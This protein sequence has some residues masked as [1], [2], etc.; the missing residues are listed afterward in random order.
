MDQAH[1]SRLANALSYGIPVVTLP[2]GARGY[3]DDVI[4]CELD[5]VPE[6][7]EAIQA[8]WATHSRQ[9][10]SDAQQFYNWATIRQQFA[11]TIH[12]LQ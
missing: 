9:A 8:N 11:E 4:T 1:I 7:L 3:G 6:T 10:R 12:A 5:Q 2:V